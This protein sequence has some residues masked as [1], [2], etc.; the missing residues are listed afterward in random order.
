MGELYSIRARARA[1]ERERTRKI[2]RL[3][4]DGGVTHWLRQP[5]FTPD[6]LQIVT[7]L[8]GRWPFASLGPSGL[9]GAYGGFFVS[10]VLVNVN[11][12]VPEKLTFRLDARFD[13]RIR[14]PCPQS[15]TSF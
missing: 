6:I 5:R 4:F 11:V 9:V 8:A 10:A 7:L 15:S 2:L 13:V 14:S 12:N 3:R 1:R